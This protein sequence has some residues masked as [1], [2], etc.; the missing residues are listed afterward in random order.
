MIPVNVQEIPE[1]IQAQLEVGAHEDM[2]MLP[3]ELPMTIRSNQVYR[4][5]SP[6]HVFPQWPKLHS[7]GHMNVNAALNSVIGNGSFELSLVP[8]GIGAGLY[9]RIKGDKGEESV[10]LG[11]LIVKEWKYR[12]FG[13]GLPLKDVIR[14]RAISAGA[15]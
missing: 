14:E 5:D 10:K 9:V 4:M 1:N 15:L 13:E 3:G 7:V 8:S 6:F 2:V 11:E 12:T